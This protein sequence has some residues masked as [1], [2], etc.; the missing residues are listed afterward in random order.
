VPAERQAY[1]GLWASLA[2]GNLA[3]RLY[4]ERLTRF[5]NWVDRFFRDAGMADRTLFPDAFWL[6]TL[7]PLWTAPAFDRCLLLAFIYPIVTI[8]VIW[9]ISG[10]V[11]QVEA[12]FGLRPALSGWERALAGGA[13]GVAVFAMW[14][15]IEERGLKRIAW[16]LP[17]Y[18]VACA[19]GFSVAGAIGGALAAA[20]LF[21][22]A[23]VVASVSALATNGTGVV[24]LATAG[25]VAYGLTNRSRFGL[26]DTRNIGTFV[27]VTIVTAILAGPLGYTKRIVALNKVISDI[28]VKVWFFPLFITLIVTTDLSAAAF[29]PHFNKWEMVGPLLLFLGLSTLLTA[30]FCWTSLG[31]TRALLRRGL[32]LGGWWPYALALVDAGLAAVIIAALALTMAVGVQAFDAL[33]VY[34]GGKP[35]LALDPLFTGIAANPSAPE[36]WWLYALLLSTMIPSLVNLVIGGTSLL[37]GL[38]WV[39]SLI[40]RFMPDRGGVLKLDRHW[41]AAVLTTQVTAGAALGIAAQAFLVVVIIGYVMPLFGADLLQTAR[42]VATFNMPARV[43]QLFGA[44]L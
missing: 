44:S 25:I 3:A 42:D 35:V 22:L 17:G 39:P 27:I 2:E 33:A 11:G 15:A 1:D 7:A 29:L 14:R 43:G 4:A 36:Y 23:G 30:P 26:G 28:R 12:V 20:L 10:Q 8:F 6:R 21:C 32:E 41:I 13:I 19:A 18:L 9:A 5:L 40:L 34:G 24:T 16:G 38:P 37:R 31:L